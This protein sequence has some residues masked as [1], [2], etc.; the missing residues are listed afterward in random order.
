MAGLRRFVEIIRLF[1]EA[2]SDWTVQ[3]I[4][5]ALKVPTSTVYRTVRELVRE[6][7]LDP[8]S[9]ARYRLGPAFV[10][11]DRQVRLTDPLIVIGTPFLDDLVGSTPIPCIAM[12]ARLYG[13][14]VVCVASSRTPGSDIETSYQRGR[15][16]PLLRGATSKA[17]LAQLPVRR[18]RKLLDTVPADQPT[19]PPGEFR[20]ELIAVRRKGFSIT[21][22]EVDKNLVGFAVPIA[23]ERSAT[24]ASISQIVRASDLDEEIERRVLRILVAIGALLTDRLESGKT[25]AS[26]APIA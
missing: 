11:F 8:S 2:K 7:F 15:P 4:A 23:S 26:A 19:A 24:V 13:D 16:M 6:G 12:L 25:A 17:I 22:G 5:E 21:R 1:D 3:E 18:L 20:H 9:D 14:R 10:E